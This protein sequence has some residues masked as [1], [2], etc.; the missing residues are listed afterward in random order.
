MDP[1]Q[2][3][4]ESVA[5]EVAGW[6]QFIAGYATAALLA[7]VILVIGFI[8][9]GWVRNLIVKACGKAKLD[10]TLSRFLGQLGR[11]A[12]LVMALVATAQTVGIETTSFVA[13]LASVGFAIGLAM[14]GSLGHFA[15]GI[16]ILVFRPFV[17]S[18]RVQI[19]GSTGVVTEIG[20]F[21]TTLLTADNITI[22]VPNGS[23]TGA[24]ITNYT[25]EGTLRGSIGVGVAYGADLQKVQ[26]VCLAAARSVPQV[27]EDPAPAIAFTDMAASSLNFN[28]MPWST[29]ADF[30]AMQ[31]NVRVAVYD[32]LNAE[33]IEIPFNQIVVHQAPT[34]G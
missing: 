25:R 21:A 6:T 13:V 5:T 34:D 16:L 3:S 2:L 7:I 14:Q 24:V 11:Y 18:D 4:A 10:P 30:L 17:L 15:S 27:L 9:A 19:G 22:M 29:A 12:I 26:Q 20:L 28:L 31:H 23:I 8:L 32:A 33:G 1:T